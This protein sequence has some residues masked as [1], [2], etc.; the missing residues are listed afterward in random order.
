MW[1]TSM[2]TLPPAL[3]PHFVATGI[4]ALMMV[5]AGVAPMLRG[6]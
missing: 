3:L 1:D 2:E 6:G 5:R 4:F